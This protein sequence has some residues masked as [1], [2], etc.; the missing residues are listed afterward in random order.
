MSLDYAA[1][2]FFAA[3]QDAASSFLEPRQRLEELYASS[4]D[5]LHPDEGL[6]EDISERIARLRE[7]R[8][9]I[10]QLGEADVN[11]LLREIVSI[12]DAIAAQLYATGRTKGVG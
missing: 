4:I 10:Y 12:Y 3:V 5:K 11:S 2:V 9:R 7:A 8:P 6:R 1:Q